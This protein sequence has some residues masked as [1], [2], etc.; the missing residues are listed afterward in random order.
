MNASRRIRTDPQEDLSGYGPAMLALSSLQR[1][2]VLAF[3]DDPTGSASAA[4]RRAGYSDKAGGERVS[5][6]YLLHNEKILTAI[7]EEITKR[8]RAGAALGHKV[9]VE[10]ASDPAHPQRLRAA[11]MLLN[12]GGFGIVTEQHV[13]VEHTHVTSEEMTRRIEHL[14]LRLGMDPAKV[15]GANGSPM[16]V[17]N[18]HSSPADVALDSEEP[19]G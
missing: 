1:R 6:H 5:A 18:G 8:F 13:K 3:I 10:V 7:N 12:R 16:K 14:A 11:E 2:F 15:L 9:L 4:A 17:I 19:G